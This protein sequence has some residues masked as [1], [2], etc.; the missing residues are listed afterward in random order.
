MQLVSLCFRTKV[1]F[2][3]FKS[4]WLRDIY[5]LF[6]FTGCVQIGSSGIKLSLCIAFLCNQCED[7]LH[8]Y[9]ADDGSIEDGVFLFL[10]EISAGDPTS[11]ETVDLIIFV[12]LDVEDP[13]ARHHL[14]A[15]RFPYNVVGSFSF[16][17][18]ELVFYSS[19]LMFLEIRLYGL[20]IGLW[21]FKISN[22]QGLSFEN[23][24]I[25]MRFSCNNSGHNGNNYV[26]FS[27]GRLFCFMRTF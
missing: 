17:V 5:N 24:G 1:R 15:L 22:T 26:D 27:T 19:Y 16:Q 21:N 23:E 12:D 2:S 4:L 10:L 6:L 11:F 18:I 20:C 8:Q 7:N 13:F 25:I 9:I 3:V 14:G